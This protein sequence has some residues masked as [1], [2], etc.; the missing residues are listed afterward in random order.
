MRGIT[1][2]WGTCLALTLVA[3]PGCEDLPGNEAIVC[4]S[5]AKNVLAGCEATYELC[6][7]GTQK[8]ACAP[9]S[10]GEL[11]CACLEDG[12]QKKLF[13]GKDECNV[14]PDTLKKRAAEGCGWTLD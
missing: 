1:A 3:A 14:S 4:K 9:D 2:A 12:Q 10:A 8:I 13:N 6:K 11:V 7:G 5:E